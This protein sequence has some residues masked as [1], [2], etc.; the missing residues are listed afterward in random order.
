VKKVDILSAEQAAA[1][2]TDGDTIAICG[3]ENVLLPDTV[4]RA[5]GERFARTGSPRNLT[6][7]H[8]IIVGMGPEKG[9]EHLAHPGMVRRAIGS[10]FSFLKTSRYTQLLKDNAFEAHVV[11]MGTLFKMLRDTASGT[12]VTYTQVGLDTFVDPA[13]E[14]GRMNQKATASLAERVEIGGQTYLRYRT[15]PVNVTFIRGTTA[16]ENG[17][18][19]LEDEPVSLGVKTLAM[20]AKA[21]GGK[22]VV[23]VRR[24]TKAGTLHPRLVEIPGIMV[25]AV[26]VDPDQSI[27]GGALLNP[28]ITGQTRLPSQH[29]AALPAGV[30]RI[31]AQRAAAEIREHEVVN[32]GVGMPVDIPKILVEGGRPDWATF[33]PEHG[34]IG[35]VPGERAIFGTNINPE[36]IIDSTQVFEWFLGGGLDISFLGF[37]Q[38]DAHG[39]VNVSKFNGIVPGCG[40][41]VDITHRTKR[42]IFCGSFSAGGAELDC[43]QGRLVIR[44]EGKYSK[45]VPKV[46]QV[47]FNAK[48]ALAKGQQ[49]LYVTERAVFS[50][51]EDGLCLEE[52]APGVDAK[53]QVLDLIPFRMRQREQLATMDAR[54]FAKENA[55]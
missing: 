51:Q 9:L 2:V 12:P 45:F 35:G 53:T 11:P 21:S 28:A 4:L 16:D 26:V 37:G 25:D 38:I 31:V 42:V 7:I 55:A 32:L 44:Q 5:L 50:L 23:Q 49:V 1:L 43:E 41:F 39:N 30:S 40:G 29:I 22:V 54:H 10:G 33:F 13:V 52:V 6:E 15:E 18:I 3:C 17:N 19:S 46:E 24:M 27:S 34:S 8:P 20:A 36:A 14:G 47:T 48:S